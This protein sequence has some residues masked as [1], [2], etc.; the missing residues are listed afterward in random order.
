MRGSKEE[1]YTV[2]L[3]ASQ[4]E[5]LIDLVNGQT[6]GDG[7]NDPDGWLVYSHA[8]AILD[9]VYAAMGL[10]QYWVHAERPT[11]ITVTMRVPARTAEHA[12]QKAQRDMHE[13]KTL[14]NWTVEEIE[15]PS[16][17]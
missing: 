5:W 17:A 8:R 10:H 15:P 7:N 13:G 12:V 1:S 6:D 9:R 3:S 2:T 14:S 11:T 4:L 16:A